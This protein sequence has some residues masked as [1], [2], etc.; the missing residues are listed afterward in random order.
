MKKMLAILL[1]LCLL[2]ITGMAANFTGN[3]T[4]AVIADDD[5]LLVVSPEEYFDGQ[6]TRSTTSVNDGRTAYCYIYYAQGAERQASSGGNNSTWALFKEYKDALIRSGY[7]E[8]IDYL[9]DKYEERWVLA[10]I[11]SGSKSSSHAIT[12]KSLLGGVWVYYTNDIR[13][14]NYDE[15]DPY[16]VSVSRSSS[17]SSGNDDKWYTCSKCHGSGAVTCTK[18]W[19]SGQV[20]TSTLSSGRKSCSTCGGRGR[21]TCDKC[22]GSGQTKTP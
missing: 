2:P 17:P 13:T 4:P 7:Y 9:K 10:Y 20:S 5:G 11:G 8:E 12:I 16:N 22:G 18:C 3:S 15:T 1:M 6:L 14:T 19:G 21:I